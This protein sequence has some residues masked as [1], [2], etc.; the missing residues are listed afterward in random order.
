MLIP[1][2]RHNLSPQQMEAS[3]EI[4]VHGMMPKLG[5]VTMWL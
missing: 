2:L 5:Q 4:R 1:Y 3:H